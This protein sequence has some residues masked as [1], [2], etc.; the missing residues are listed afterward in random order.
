MTDMTDRNQDR[1]GFRVGWWALAIIS[2]GMTIS[3]P[4][5]WLFGAAEDIELAFIGLTAVNLYTFITLLIPYKR[6]ESWAWWVVWAIVATN[7][8]VYP[9]APEAGQWYLLVA[10]VQAAA[11]LL[12]RPSFSPVPNP[13][14]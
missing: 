11:Q 6:R 1:I 10:A 7:A 3:L 14:P 5:L 12:T 8:I 9:Y 2:G 13:A 4:I